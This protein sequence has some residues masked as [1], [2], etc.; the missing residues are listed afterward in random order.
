MSLKHTVHIS[1]VSQRTIKVRLQY[2]TKP[3][4]SQELCHRLIQDQE[5]FRT[6]LP[7]AHL[8]QPT[9]FEPVV[10]FGDGTAVDRIPAAK[11]IYRLSNTE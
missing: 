3:D 5:C 4:R 10:A 8:Q 9:R 6:Q 1:A 11:A 2:F 7:L